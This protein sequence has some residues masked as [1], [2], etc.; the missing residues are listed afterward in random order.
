MKNQTRNYFIKSIFIFVALLIFGCSKEEAVTPAAAELSILGKW[1]ILV[2]RSTENGKSVYD[3]VGKTG[4]YIEFTNNDYI[5][6]IEGDKE[7]NQYKVIEKNKKIAFIGT[8]SNG[9]D[10]TVEIR[11]LTSKTMTLYQEYV[12][13]NVRYVNY[14][15]LKRF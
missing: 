14:L 15:D 12:E 10:E 4:D 3:Y 5:S 11:N 6:F 13:N 9:G 8:S 7:A 1:E 2:L